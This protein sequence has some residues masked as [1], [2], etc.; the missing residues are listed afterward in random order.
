MLYKKIEN[1]RFHEDDIVAQK[2]E[3]MSVP[4]DRKQC[5]HGR[6]LAKKPE[7]D[8]FCI[9]LFFKKIP[10]LNFYDSCYS[11]RTYSAGNATFAL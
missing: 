11:V 9:F 6:V 7:K 10:T 1:C 2:K 3:I 5:S 4:L 8:H